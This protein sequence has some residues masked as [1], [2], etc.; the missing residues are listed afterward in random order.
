MSYL[1]KNYVTR[2]EKERRLKAAHEKES[3]TAK[4][5]SIG[6]VYW[7]LLEKIRERKNLKSANK[8]IEYCIYEIGISEG[9]ES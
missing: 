2:P 9:L 4:T 8:A 6:S 3:R 5:I 1:D 7:V